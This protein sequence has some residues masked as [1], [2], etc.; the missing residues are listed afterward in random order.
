MKKYDFALN[1]TF[2]QKDLQDLIPKEI[3]E[4]LI[5]STG[6][7]SQIVFGS[8][9]A[10][11]NYLASGSDLNMEV[12]QTGADKWWVFGGMR[13]PLNGKMANIGGAKAG[14][15]YVFQSMVKRFTA[16]HTPNCSI[17]IQ[18]YVIRVKFAI[19]RTPQDPLTLLLLIFGD[20]KELIPTLTKTTKAY[21]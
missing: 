13:I 12:T 18:C 5:L 8:S 6:Y 3:P 9:Y 11:V 2:D 17:N 4:N 15:T 19:T 16:P 20:G 7:Y 1:D 10:Y 14:K 21:H